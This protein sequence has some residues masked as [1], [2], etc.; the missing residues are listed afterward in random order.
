MTTK[1]ATAPMNSLFRGILTI[2]LC[3]ATAS[4]AFA[5]G[6]RFDAQGVYL[7]EYGTPVPPTV[8]CSP[9]QVCEIVLEPDEIVYDKLAG[10][11]VRWTIGS[12]VAGGR[13]N[14]PTIF[15]KPVDVGTPASPIATNLIIT[16]NRRTYEIDL[17]SVK[18]TKYTRYGFYYPQ[19]QLSIAQASVVPLSSPTPQPVVSA[20]LV[21]TLNAPSGPPPRPDTY[22]I[23]GKT[24]YRP[25]AV[26]ND[27]VHT[28]IQMPPRAMA[29]SIY[30]VSDNGTIGM[31]N[32]HPPIN[33]VYTIDGTPNHILL[34]GGIGKKVPH[35]DIIRK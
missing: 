27:L 3:A 18:T 15:L 33:D 10:D 20:P 14:I 29:P 25:I 6:G 28:Y 26:W 30:T 35:I 8:N 23:Q 12:G 34:I 13:G 7:F 4:S 31:I 22:D 2:L 21:I 16:T 5:N 11:T 24:D 17:V 9:D 19:E 1:K 32:Y